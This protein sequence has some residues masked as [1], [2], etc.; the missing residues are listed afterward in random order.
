MLIFSLISIR[1]SAQCTVVITNP[2]AVCSPATVDITAASV[3]QGSPAG[4]TYTYWTDA[5]AT[6]SYAT[7]TTATNGT[8]YIKGDNGAGCTS[9]QP[10]IVTV[11]SI[12]TAP[13]V[14]TLTQPTCTVSTGSAALSGLPAT[15]DWTITASPGG[16]TMTG[17]GTTTTFVGLLAGTTYTFKVANYAGCT[18]PS[19][20]SAV[21]QAQPATPSA[22][23]VGT[24][25]APTCSVSTGSVVLSSLP[26]GSWTLKRYPGGVTSSGSGTSTTISGLATGTYNFSVT[27]ASN[28]TSAALSDD[29]VI[30]AQPT[31]LAAPVPGTAT[32]PTCSTATGSVPLSGLPSSGTWIVTLSTGTTMT[33]TGTTTTFTGITAGTYTFTVS[34]TGF[35][36]SAASS[37]VTIITQPV[38]PSAPLIGTITQP[39]CALS[40]GSVV[41]NSLPAS[42]SWVLTRNP[43]N[44]TTSGSGTSVTI[45][46]LSQGTYSFTVTNAGGCTSP[47]SASLTVNAP[48]AAPGTPEFTTD[49]TLGFGHAVIT[50]SQPVGSG[51]QYSIDGGT[52]QSSA[53]FSNVANGNHYLAVRNA[54]GCVTTTGIFTTSCGCVNPPLITLGETGGTTCGTTAVTV[55]GNSF[56]GSATSVTLTSNG[57]GSFDHTSFTTAPFSFT[58]TPAVSDGGKTITLTLTTNNPLGSPC[59]AAVGTYVLVVGA[60]PSAPTIGT[61]T[62]LTCTSS[63]GSVLLT[64]LPS[65]GTWT[66]TRLPDNI[67]NTGTG[68]SSTESGLT[69]GTYNF[70]V[71]NAAGCTSL[72][73]ADVVIA[74]QPNAPAAPVIGTITQTTCTSSTGTVALSGLPAGSWI[75]TRLPG[76]STRSGSGTT[77]S[78]N[79]IPSG[80]YTFTVTNATGCVS[81]Q[82]ASFTVN[83]QPATPTV[84]SVGTIVG[85]TCA[86]DTGTVELYGLPSGPWVLT[87]LPGNVTHAG[88]GT[89]ETLTGIRSGTYNFTV[90]NQAGCVSSASANVIMPARPA[91]P[92][93]P[94][95]G[96]ITQPTFVVPTGSVVL[97]GLPSSGAWILTR[98]PDEVTTAGTGSAFTVS[99]LNGGLYNFIVTNTVGC[100]SDTSADVIISTPGK[101]ILLITNPPAVCAP[102]KVD[103]TDPSITE[104]STTGLTFTYWLDADATQAYATPETADSGSYYI[105]G[106]TVSGYFNIKPVNAS[107]VQ[108][109]VPDAG[110]DQKLSAEFSTILAAV[111]IEGETGT[112]SFVSG[113]GSISDVTDPQT[114]LSDLTYGTNVLKWVVTN[115]VCP[116]DSDNISIVVGDLT[117]PTLITPNGDNKNEYFVIQGLESLGK[118]E[119][120]IIDRRGAVVFKDSK[121]E[122]KWNGLD[123]NGNDLP[124]DTYFY[125][126]K[127]S[128]G[129]NLSGYIV[130]RR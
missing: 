76:G 96:T 119:L 73:S 81:A 44:V 26:A 95:I 123:Y 7:P 49:C 129:R 40:T 12:P 84:P 51:L 35:C 3:T 114:S 48:P 122:N 80:T 57:A 5:A 126:I 92:G 87:R 65:T 13:V 118:T 53:V 54:D 34:L 9:V 2:A 38:T 91:T 82:S 42:G 88:S 60:I 77:Y 8:Y 32:Q 111:V 72:Q 130:I 104:G 17:N 97:S 20:G 28:C 109:P 33:G 50:I 37:S 29:V 69:A 75:L 21:I 59:A 58:Y 115:G 55:S 27:N 125:L 15:N 127:S 116:K 106:T 22:P 11:A 56:G 39:T 64:G 14:G 6:L 86:S 120:V 100:P 1:L 4:L 70:T 79:T 62:S 25:T 128:K 117:I 47:S 61:I 16:A 23:V 36:T 112:W 99:G 67:T 46:G 78:A 71:I 110:P 101:P 74:P 94:V 107:I 18:S 30:P 121:Y 45:S 103:L 10:V 113:H 68:T 52:Y 41:L 63:T 89:I 93:T 85:P 24:I 108:K 105:K 43:G 31:T 124:N 19:S 66:I 98:L 83:D 90:T 102:A